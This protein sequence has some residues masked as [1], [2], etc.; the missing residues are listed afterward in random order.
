MP[1]YKVDLWVGRFGADAPSN[2]FE[3]TY[4]DNDDEPISPFVGD[5]GETFVDHDW[6]EHSWLDSNASVGKIAA[7]HV[8]EN[9]CRLIEE[10]AKQKG[11]SRANVFV[12]INVGEVKS[13]RSVKV[14][15]KQVEL[16]YLGVFDNT[17]PA[18]PLADTIAKAEA[19]DVDAQATIGSIY[20]FPPPELRDIQDIDKAEYWLLKAA[21]AGKTSI[22]NRLYHL[23]SGD[24]GPAQPEKAF[25][26]IEKAAQQ[27]WGS[28]LTNLAK[29]YA[30]GFGTPQNDVLALKWE[31]LSKCIYDSNSY[32]QLIFELLERMA[33]EEIAESERL[34]LEWIATTKDSATRFGEMKRNPIRSAGALG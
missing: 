34:A 2:Y 27:G 16:I 28:D 4:S 9:C 1:E 29:S 12:I 21:N 5:Q 13:P 22:Y 25:Y 24:Y 10:A 15:V 14:D 33:A 3:E 30:D 7:P 31:F 23:Y 19:G 32:D 11:I 17:P 18:F 6:M 20:I 8:T 26:W